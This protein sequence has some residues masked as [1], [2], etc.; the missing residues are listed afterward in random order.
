[1]NQADYLAGQRRSGTK[2]ET[3]SPWHCMPMSVMFS[4]Y[5]SLSLPSVDDGINALP[6]GKRNLNSRTLTHGH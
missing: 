3:T 6:L 2:D 5:R 4:D 1:M